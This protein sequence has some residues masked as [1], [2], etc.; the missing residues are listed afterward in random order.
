MKKY[1]LLLL[2]LLPFNVYASIKLVSGDLNTIGSTVKI[3]DELFYVIGKE[4][5]THIQLMAKYNIGVGQFFEENPI[6]RQTIFAVGALEGSAPFI[7][8]VCDYTAQFT[9]PSMNTQAVADGFNNY[10]SYLTSEG[11]NITS[12]GIPSYNRYL[13]LSNNNN[14]KLNVQVGYEFLY[15]DAYWLTT[16]DDFF[17]RFMSNGNSRVQQVGYGYCPYMW[18]IRPVITVEISGTLDRDET[19]G[20]VINPKLTNSQYSLGDTYKL[21]DEE[22]YVIGKEDETHLKLLSKNNLGVGNG[23]SDPVYKQDNEAMGWVNNSDSNK[24]AIKF[25]ESAYW[26]NSH[27]LETTLQE[28]YGTDYPA[29]IYDESSNAYASVNSYVDY[30]KSKGY[31]VT[32]RLIKQEEL[33]GLGCNSNTYSCNDAP[34]WVYS[35]SY[36]T[37]SAANPQFLN[38]VNT[39]GRYGEDSYRQENR[40]GV[41]PVILLEI[42][43]E[44]IVPDD[45]K[46]DSE[47]EKVKGKEEI[48]VNPNTGSASYTI[49]CFVMLLVAIAIYIRIFNKSYFKK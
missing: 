34:E 26:A 29:H 30:L 13:E 42:E 8:S 1:L 2:L 17:D 24:G 5:D 38:Y 21:G 28:Q 49:I 31:N 32:G 46:G 37:G 7:G 23:Y 19:N 48:K 41:R 40:Y 12:Y 11:V 22:F 43:S 25:S 36:W 47:Y 10:I 45:Y 39:S 14:D 15:Q 35:T 20:P 33:N 3:G 9:F 4:D 16:R 44:E 27:S 6:Y 18:G